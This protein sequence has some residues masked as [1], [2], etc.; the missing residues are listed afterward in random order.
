MTITTKQRERRRLGISGSDAPAIVGASPFATPLSVWLDKTRPLQRE[1]PSAIMEI[2]TALEPFIAEQWQRHTGHQVEE[3]ADTV[4]HPRFSFLIGHPDRRLV[5]KPEGLECK[6][7]AFRH[8]DWGPP[9]SDLV[10]PYVYLQ[11]AHYMLIT[12]FRRWHVAAQL[13]FRELR[14]YTVEWDAAIASNLLK[15]ERAFWRLVQRGTPPPMMSP[16]DVGRMFPRDA[17]TA[18]AANKKMR[19]TMEALKHARQEA[20]SWGD[21]ADV[22]EGTVKAFM[23]EHAML[24]DRAGAPL[25]T[26]RSARGHKEFDDRRFAAKHPELYKQFL[27]RVPGSRR[28]LIK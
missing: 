17:G 20:A 6:L 25:V 2:G 23:G 19:E 5:R 1:Q 21:L 27:R 3:M 28:F 11:C 22:L 9:D 24:T 7:V 4:V 14:C 8:E 16:R 18:I 12:G 15:R 26:W 10:P 13:G